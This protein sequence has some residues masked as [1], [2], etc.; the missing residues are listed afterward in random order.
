MEKLSPI[1]RLLKL[2]HDCHFPIRFSH[3]QSKLLIK[4]SPL[5]STYIY[6]MD[7]SV[8]DGEVDLEVTAQKAL[9]YLIPITKWSDEDYDVIWEK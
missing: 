1:Y 7:Y 4:K 2:C 8:V 3:E 9:D 5:K 6:A